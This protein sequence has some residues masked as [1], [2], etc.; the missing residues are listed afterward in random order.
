MIGSDEREK[1]LA[2]EGMQN[3]QEN[4]SSLEQRSAL[5]Q[6]SLRWKK[7]ANIS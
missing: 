6:G 7:K 2:F 4:V 1:S 5:L 3:L